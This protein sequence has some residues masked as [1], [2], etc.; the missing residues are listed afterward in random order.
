[1]MRAALLLL[2]A[3]PPACASAPPPL[4]DES[5]AAYAAKPFDKTAKM[6]ARDA[7]GI[8]RGAAVVAEYRCS[9]LCPDYNTRIIHFDLEPGPACD[10]A[11]GVTHPVLV[12][13]GIAAVRKNF[14][15]PKVLVDRKL[16]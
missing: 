13:M 12:P 8:L 15:V 4:S 14:C 16:Q 3:L 5:L 1:M 10:K 7:L 6:G 11:G 9:D 2:L